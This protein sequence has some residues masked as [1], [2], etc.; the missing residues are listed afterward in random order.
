MRQRPVDSRGGEKLS[1]WRSEEEKGKT[2]GTQ[3]TWGTRKRGRTPWVDNEDSRN[4]GGKQRQGAPQGAPPWHPEGCGH[5]WQGQKA[6]LPQAECSISE[7][8][9]F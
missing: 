8:G 5:S 7:L 4:Q 1:A 2:L 6:H 9:S 3:Q